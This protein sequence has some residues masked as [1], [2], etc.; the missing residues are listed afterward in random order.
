MYRLNLDHRQA[1]AGESLIPQDGETGF[2]RTE[3]QTEVGNHQLRIG[4][5]RSDRRIRLMTRHPEVPPPLLPLI[6]LFFF[7]RVI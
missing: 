3:L 2:I 7:V 4:F 6:R 1:F 5:D